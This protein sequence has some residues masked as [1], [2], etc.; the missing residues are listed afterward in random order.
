[1]EGVEEGDDDW[2]MVV[3]MPRRGQIEDTSCRSK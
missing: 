3:G 1:M 2:A